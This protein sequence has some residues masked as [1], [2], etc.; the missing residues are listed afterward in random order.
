[1]KI[2]PVQGRTRAGLWSYRTLRN[3]V[4]SVMYS[5]VSVEPSAFI[6]MGHS[7]IMQCS[8]SN[9]TLQRV[10]GK[11]DCDV[12][13]AARV[14]AVKRTEQCGR[15]CTQNEC[16]TV[17]L[18]VPLPKFRDLCCEIMFSFFLEGPAVTAV[19]SRCSWLSGTD[20]TVKNI[21]IHFQFKTAIWFR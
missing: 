6:V 21:G 19:Q 10:D 16:L 18:V 17:R 3:A 12:R 7:C 9:C 1:M 4:G 2:D 11:R 5:D 20:K 13:T 15:C 14:N 8:F